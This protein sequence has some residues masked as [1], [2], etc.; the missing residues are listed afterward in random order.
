[1]KL[2]ADFAHLIRENE[3]LA[4]YTWLQIG[5]LARYFAE[6]TT[7]AELQQLVRAAHKENLPLRV[8]GGGS[9]LLVQESQSDA[10]VLHLAAADLTAIKI[11]GHKVTVGGGAKLSHVIS[12][13][14]GQGLA[15]LEHLVGI[16]GT[17]GGAVVGNAG[18][19]NGDIGSHVVRVTTLDKAGQMVARHAPALQFSYRR[20]D[21]EDVIVVE[22][23]LELEGGD[24]TELT[25]R[26]QNSWIVKRAGQPP[27]NQRAA[28]A[29]VDPSGISAA[30]LIDQAG[31]KGAAEGE[32]SLSS[33]YPGYIVV[34]GNATSTQV[35][36]LLD[37]VRKAV[38]LR[39]GIQLQSHLRIW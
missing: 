34:S 4:P 30:E 32:V 38:A 29:F 19:V 15:G 16:P 20:S 17:M 11:D 27:T 6:P 21:L 18:V 14:V 36:A 5:G 12:R 26:M 24:V 37:R 33:Q 28:I 3:P 13:V 10:L 39:T 2:L 23:E 31:L 25:R 1:M 7:V 22:V 9:N 8:L 35:L